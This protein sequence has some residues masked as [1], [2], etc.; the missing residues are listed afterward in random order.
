MKE[1]KVHNPKWIHEYVSYF[2]QTNPDHIAISFMESL[3]TPLEHISYL[4]LDQ[5]SN[6]IANHLFQSGILVEDIIMISM[7]KSILLYAVVLAILKVGG[8]YCFMDSKLP[9]SRKQYMIEN[10]GCKRIL[11]DSE[12]MPLFSELDSVQAM[13]IDMEQIKSESIKFQNIVVSSNNLAYVIYTSG[14]TGVPK[15]VLV[16]H[17]NVQYCMNGFDLMI[18]LNSNDRFLQFASLA[19]DVSVFEIFYC[20]MKGAT[21]VSASQE[22]ILGNLI[23][24]INRLQVTHMDLTPT[25]CSLIPSRDLVPTVQVL[26][27]GG[28]GMTQKVNYHNHRF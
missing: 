21:L 18:P 20:F 17:G 19:F 11:C 14:S 12:S 5:L 7:P 1:T 8:A 25:V 4:E 15:G 9:E 2:A 22:L 10:S 28:E 3:D 27:S 23:D 13:L 16:E 24:S 26:V 6:Q